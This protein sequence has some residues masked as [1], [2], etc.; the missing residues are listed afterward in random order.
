MIRDLKDDG[1]YGFGVLGFEF[2]LFSADSRDIRTRI[3]L[4]AIYS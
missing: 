1:I 2:R 3:S 4:P